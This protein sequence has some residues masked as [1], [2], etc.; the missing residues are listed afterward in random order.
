M[1]YLEFRYLDVELIRTQGE[2]LFGNSSGKVDLES[3]EELARDTWSDFKLRGF[4]PIFLK[5]AA[6]FVRNREQK[7]RR[8][9]T[10]CLSVLKRNSQVVGSV[11]YDLNE[12]VPEKVAEVGLS[13]AIKFTRDKDS[14]LFSTRIDSTAAFLYSNP[15]SQAVASDFV[16]IS[17]AIKIYD[18]L[19]VARLL[20]EHDFS[21][22]TEALRQI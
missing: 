20:N 11:V 7:E 10:R 1:T 4:F 16:P 9:I 6:Y 17:K 22:H 18:A 5:N 3:I 12:Y 13:Y 15:I 8:A 14:A 19:E 21:T 2:C